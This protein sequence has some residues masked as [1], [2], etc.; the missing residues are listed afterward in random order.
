VVGNK[1]AWGI[2][3]RRRGRKKR[4]QW[5]REEYAG[6]DGRGMEGVGKERGEG[7][8]EWATRARHLSARP[9]ELPVAHVYRCATGS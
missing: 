2:R 5:G 9:V 1:T 8:G 4:R 7:S 3:W 6:G